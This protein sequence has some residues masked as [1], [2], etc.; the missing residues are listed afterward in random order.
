MSGW[1]IPSWTN[2]FFEWVLIVSLLFLHIF[3]AVQKNR[4]DNDLNRLIDELTKL[5]Q[6][7]ISIKDDK[8]YV[9]K[10]KFF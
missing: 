10:H 8:G 2:R 5:F 4:N 7:L 3:L 6:E 9:E 1:L